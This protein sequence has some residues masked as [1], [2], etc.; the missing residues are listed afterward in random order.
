MS[1]I[2]ERE[3]R[4][5]HQISQIIDGLALIAAVQSMDRVKVADTPYARE[6][7]TRAE[8]FQEFIWEGLNLT[9]YEEIWKDETSDS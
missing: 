1:D 9:S 3:S 5:N 7:L 8:L 4:L 2:N 6:L